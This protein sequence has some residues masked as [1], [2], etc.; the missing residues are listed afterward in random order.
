M[1]D[2]EA[3]TSENISVFRSFLFMRKPIL[4]HDKNHKVIFHHRAVV[5]QELYM[6]F[7][8]LFKH[9]FVTQP[10]KNPPLCSSIDFS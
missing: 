6:T 5:K 9:R 1:V 7:V 4:E 8:M 10:L 2:P 3:Q